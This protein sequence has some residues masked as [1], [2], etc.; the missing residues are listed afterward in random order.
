MFVKQTES[1]PGYRLFF[2][3]TVFLHI[4]LVVRIC[5]YLQIISERWPSSTLFLVTEFLYSSILGLCSTMQQARPG[6]FQSRNYPSTLGSYLYTSGRTSLSSCLSFYIVLHM[7][8][9]TSTY[10][11]LQGVRLFALLTHA[12]Q[13]LFVFTQIHH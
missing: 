9:T 5:K 12:M 8:K 3:Q 6:I 11:L 7:Y 4:K 13:F 2:S 10:Y 1:L